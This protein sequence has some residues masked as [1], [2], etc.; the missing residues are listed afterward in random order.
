MLEQVVKE[1]TFEELDNQV[2]SALKRRGWCCL[3]LQK[4]DNDIVILTANKSIDDYPKGYPVYTIGEFN[5][6]AEADISTAR[7]LHK[8]KK[9]LNGIIKWQK[10]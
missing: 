2:M 3:E 7:L 10:C 5:E 4:L 1:M 6:L 9:E 8:A